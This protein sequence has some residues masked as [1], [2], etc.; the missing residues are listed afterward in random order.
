MG[1]GRVRRAGPRTTRRVGTAGVDEVYSLHS[2]SGSAMIHLVSRSQYDWTPERGSG[3]DV[4]GYNFVRKD[5]EPIARL[6]KRV[7]GRKKV[8]TLTSGSRSEQMPPRATF[9]H[10]E[11]TLRDW[12]VV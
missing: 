12:G 9:D 6:S 2:A 8:W 1:A 5:G 4:N 10:A 11:H 3:F 7:N